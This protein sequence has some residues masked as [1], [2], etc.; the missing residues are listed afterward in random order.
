MNPAISY[1]IASVQRSGTH[2]L[3]SILRSTGIAGLPAEHFLSKPGETWEKRW[4][5]PSRVAYVQ[6][7]LRQNTA[8]DG[9]FGTV[10]MWSYF[11]RMLQMLQEIPAYKN[12]NGAQLLAAVFNKPK[13]IWMRRRNHVE[14]A[15]SWAMA[16]Q[17]GVW[18]QKAEEKSQ[19]RAIPKFN[20]KVID[21]WCK[22]IAAHDKGWANYFRKNQIDPLVLFYEDA[23]A[24]HRAAAEHVL[25]F[26]GLPFPPGLEI[27][28]PAVEKQ[29]TRISEEWAARY[30]KLKRA[31][32]G[33]LA[34]II[35]RLRV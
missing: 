27:P 3:C 22:R 8:A 24:S 34:R 2:L 9:V 13:Y 16:C 30:L 20:F 25:E 14:Q 32:R 26:L 11:E 4:D 5:T 33:K 31:K 1:I 21:E 15:V 28:P 12:L 23:V 29:A 6:H 7:V 35:R 10:I 19:P 18:T 17:T